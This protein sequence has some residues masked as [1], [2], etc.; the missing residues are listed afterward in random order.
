MHTQVVFLNRTFL[1]KGNAL[2]ETVTH[3]QPTL[4]FPGAYRDL[5]LKCINHYAV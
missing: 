3:T 5:P 4:S 1:L 2:R